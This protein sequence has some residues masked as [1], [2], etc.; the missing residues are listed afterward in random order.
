MGKIA[1]VTDSTCCLPAELVARYS[2]HVVPLLICISGKSHRDNVDITPQEVYRIMRRDEDL[3][4]TSVPTPDD[5]SKAFISAGKEAEGIVCITLTGLQSKTYETAVL[6]K[7]IAEEAMPRTAIEV[8]DSRAV[9]GAL[10][11]MVLEAA[12]AADRGA[13]LKEVCA[14]ARKTMAR[15]NFLAMVDTLHFLAR[16]GRIARAAAWAGAVLNMKPVLEHSTAIGETTPF[17][18]PRSKAK[19]VELMLQTMTERVGNS[20]VHVL[21]HHA[22]ELEEGEKLKAEVARRFKCAEIYL[23]EF[24]PIMGVHAGPGVLALAFWKEDAAANSR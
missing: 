9:S 12:R 6:A 5:F 23:T 11:F 14:A 4:T 18:R 21:V 16:T 15:I 24:T 1:V 8:I 10:G 2:I 17:A 7:K 13:D 19:A 22:D 3:P 20:K